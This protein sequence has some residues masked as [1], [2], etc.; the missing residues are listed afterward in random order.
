MPT[1]FTIRIMSFMVATCRR[2]A[3]RTSSMHTRNGLV[4]LRKASRSSFMPFQEKT[5]ASPLHLRTSI[6]MK[7][8]KS[9]NMSSI[10]SRTK[11]S[12]SVSTLSLLTGAMSDKWVYLVEAEDIGII[13]PYHAQVMKIRTALRSMPHSAKDIQVASVE[14]FQGQ[15]TVF[16]WGISHLTHYL[17]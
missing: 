10:F 12:L 6:S 5:S 14:L 8:L 13:T 1:F 9:R 7:S 4:Y 3:L 16:A 17:S 11:G 2:K 15:V